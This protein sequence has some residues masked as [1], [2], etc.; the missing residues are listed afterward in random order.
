MDAITPTALINMMRESAARMQFL[1]KVLKL[2]QKL[3]EIQWFSLKHAQQAS[4]S[5]TEC[6]AV[7]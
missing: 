4:P 6:S 5:P 7:Q 2:V 3:S 1:S